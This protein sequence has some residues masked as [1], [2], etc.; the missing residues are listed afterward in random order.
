[1]GDLKQVLSDTGDTNNGSGEN[2]K[3]KVVMKPMTTNNSTITNKSLGLK[4]NN[5]TMNINPCS[6][7]EVNLKLEVY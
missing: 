2:M 4:T 7:K 1:M 6:M 3:Q 5:N